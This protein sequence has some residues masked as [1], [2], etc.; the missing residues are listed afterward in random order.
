[1]YCRKDEKRFGSRA[2][3]QSRRNFCGGRGYILLFVDFRSFLES[4]FSCRRHST[5]WSRHALMASDAV[6]IEKSLVETHALPHLHAD[7]SLCW[8]CRC[9]RRL[10]Q[11]D[12]VQ[13]TGSVQASS[14]TAVQDGGMLQAATEEQEWANLKEIKKRLLSAMANANVYR[15]GGDLEL[16]LATGQLVASAG[17]IFRIRKRPDLL[18]QEW[19][20]L[21]DEQVNLIR[22]NPLAVES[23]ASQDNVLFGEDGLNDLLQRIGNGNQGWGLEPVKEI[24]DNVFRMTTMGRKLRR[25][26]RRARRAARRKVR[27]SDTALGRALLQDDLL[28]EEEESGAACEPRLTEEEWKAIEMAE[29]EAA[30]GKLV[31]CHPHSSASSRPLQTRPMFLM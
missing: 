23:P 16:E 26:Q 6:R 15:E 19:D 27:R 24:V 20:S 13:I 8:G 12:K 1:M 9:R 30:D 29:R 18:M 25:A 22:D 10:L 11:A 4:G 28:K 21:I 17:I 3:Y 14:T 7:V 5:V 2:V 31:P